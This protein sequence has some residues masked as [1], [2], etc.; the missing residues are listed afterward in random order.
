MAAESTDSGDT[1]EPEVSPDVA[2]DDGA[3]AQA[4]GGQ[5][6]NSTLVTYSSTFVPFDSSF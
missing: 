5:M 4:S 6:N 3:L 2:I 1:S